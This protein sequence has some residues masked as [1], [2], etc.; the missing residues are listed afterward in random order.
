MGEI[1]PKEEEAP[2]PVKKRFTLSDG[3]EVST[4]PEVIKVKPLMKPFTSV[5]PAPSGSDAP[6]SPSSENFSMGRPAPDHP[7][8]HLPAEALSPNPLII[9]VASASVALVFAALAVTGLFPHL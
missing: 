2:G 6:E 3:S 8:A 5:L 4:Q 7:N 9:D 1:T